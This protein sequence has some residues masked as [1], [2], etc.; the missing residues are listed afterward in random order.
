[1]FGWTIENITVIMPESGI[2]NENQ[3]LLQLKQDMQLT[4]WSGVHLEKLIIVPQLVEFPDLT[5]TRRF[6]TMFTH[7]IIGPYP[8][9]DESSPHNSIQFLLRSIL[10]LSSHLCI[11]LPG[12][13]C[14]WRFPETLYAYLFSLMN[15]IRPA[16][17][18]LDNT[19]VGILILA[20][21][22]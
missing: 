20:T 11:G 6:I 19:R 12:I 21:P 14:P 3:K 4:T 17:L 13:H 18:T 10:I 9:T 2:K 8:E 16:N 15:A 7:P 5:G 22:R 1:M